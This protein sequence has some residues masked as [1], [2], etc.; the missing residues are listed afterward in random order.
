MCALVLSE[1]GSLVRTAERLH[2]SHTNV[3]RKVK[4]LQNAWGI[5]LFRRNLTGFEVTEQ[6]RNALPEIRKSI[7]HMQRGFDG[8]IYLSVKNRRPLTVGHSL[9]V[10]GKVLPYLEQRKIDSD[11]FSGVEIN[12]DTTVNLVQHVLR[13]ILH[14]GFGVGPIQDKDLW[15]APITREYFSVCIA[16]DHPL[17][18]K[19]RLSVHDLI[20]ET[21]YWMPRSVHPA[22]FQH[23]S[24]YLY[25][26]G[27]QPHKLR[28]A[29]AIIQGIDLAASRLGVALVPASA[30]RFQH[31]GVLF[32]PLTDKL[33]YIDTL[34]F[35]RRDQMRNGL[36]AFVRGAISELSSKKDR[37]Q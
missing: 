2:T 14:V 7:D 33:I 30:A 15:I 21:I 5:E 9:Y 23:V 1:E 32:K 27:I 4:I 8:A 31:A 12:A 20:G 25:G 28:E 36:D 29:R 22:F 34:V 13:G 24:G 10:H 35:A 17:R 37:S 3:G 16:A 6:G 11:D 26:V 19:I 18:N